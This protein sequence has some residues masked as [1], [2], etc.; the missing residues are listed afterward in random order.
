MADKYGKK[1]EF[2]GLLAGI[3]GGAVFLAFLFLLNVGLVGSLVGGA[4]GF[5][6]GL[7]I[8][9]RKLPKVD[10]SMSGVSPEMLAEALRDGRSKL[11]E[12]RSI[13]SRI[14]NP[15]VQFK[16][17]QIS[18][19]T[20]KI[21]LDIQKDPNDL[22]PARQ[23]LSYYLEATCKI[24]RGY[25]DLSDKKVADPDV[26]T[27]LRRVEGLLDTIRKAFLQQHAQLLQ[28]DVMDLDTEI[29]VLE[30]TIKMEGLGEK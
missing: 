18:D 4:V 16:V 8:T 12:M 29:Q 19:I 23:F 20:E 30:N 3:L 2:N 15:L 9:R 1:T 27:S 13:A 7:L 26:Q 14:Q 17:K 10:M 24:L 22:K 6:A 21:L 11:A 28:N 25:V 5:V